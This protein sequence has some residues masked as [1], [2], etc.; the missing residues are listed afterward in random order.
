MPGLS[1]R[2]E[3][4]VSRSKFNFGWVVVAACTLIIALSYGVLYSYSVFFKPLADHFNWDRGTVSLI[5]S[6]LLLIRGAIAIG[7]GWL[8]DRYGPFKISALCGLLIALGLV[9]SS[10][11]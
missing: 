10:Q 8:A 2:S 3:T 5:Y 4:T 11:V 1:S 7:I 6:L 9:L